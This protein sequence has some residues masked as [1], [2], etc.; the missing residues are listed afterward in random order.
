[1]INYE[2]KNTSQLKLNAELAMKYLKKIDTIEIKKT[3]TSYIYE[4]YINFN[5][6]LIKLGYIEFNQDNFNITLFE[7]NFSD[8]AII[9]IE[10][11]HL[12][13]TCTDETMQRIVK[14]L[15]SNIH[16]IF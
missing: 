15:N 11:Y 2:L 10:L 5:S 13:I 4:I 14:F 12:L 1:M 6:L 8:M 9:K 7:T 16:Y 3:N